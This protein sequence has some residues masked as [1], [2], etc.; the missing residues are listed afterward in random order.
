MIKYLTAINE[1]IKTFTSGI[2]MPNELDIL[3]RATP[4]NGDGAYRTKTII[5][6]LPRKCPRIVQTRQ[7]L[8]KTQK[9][10]LIDTPLLKIQPKHRYSPQ[11]TSQ[12]SNQSTSTKHKVRIVT[13]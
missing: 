10:V 5:T 3:D 11:S 4:A 1:R 12:S 9:L 8:L 13:D 7:S 2:S 6:T